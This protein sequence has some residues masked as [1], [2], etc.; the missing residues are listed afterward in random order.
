MSV[1]A[2]S[3]ASISGAV[4]VAPVGTT[5]PT[6]AVTAIASGFTS[7]GA[8][9]EDG[10]TVS[11]DLSNKEIKA[12]GGAIVAVLHTGRK[13]T[14]KLTCLES[15]NVAALG[16]AF[17]D[18]TGTVASGLTI[19]GNSK[20]VDHHAVIFDMITTDGCAKRIVLP[21]AVTTNVGDITYADGDIS[22]LSLTLIA[23]PDASGNCSYSYTKKKEA[24]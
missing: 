3:P 20:Q 11:T 13:E 16:I 14:Y 21:D 4:H 19:K 7:V 12:W 15:D 24:K 23:L 8:I 2:T 22:S 18:V 5:L 1:S 10:L 17:A 6:D 9:S